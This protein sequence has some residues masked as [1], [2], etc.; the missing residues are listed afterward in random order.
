MQACNVPPVASSVS[1]TEPNYCI[2]G[3]TAFI[4]WSYSDFENDP[5]S[6]YQVQV[7]TN[8][9]FTSLVVDSGKVANSGTSYFASGMS[10]NT[11]NW[12][13][14][15]VWDSKD[16]P[17]AWQAMTICNGSGCSGGTHWKTPFHAFPLVNFTFAPVNPQTR[18]PVQFTDTTIFY[19]GAGNNNHSWAW[20][21]GN[22]SSSVQNPT[23]TYTTAGSYNITNAVT[24]KEGYSCSVSQVLNVQNVIPG[25]QEVNPVGGAN[26]Q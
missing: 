14:V 4:T 16:D 1:A 26:V 7:A 18:K 19:D 8:S 25:W 13:R 12:A 17:S 24:D 20:L 21:L 5:Q 9:S 3:P 10:F 11:N 2:S 15:R 22:G 6:A 23:R